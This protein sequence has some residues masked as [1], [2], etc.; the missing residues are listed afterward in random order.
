MVVGCFWQEGLS[1]PPTAPKSAVHLGVQSIGATNEAGSMGLAFEEFQQ[2]MRIRFHCDNAVPSRAVDSRF[3]VFLRVQDE[4]MQ[5][6]KADESPGY[7]EAW[8][9]GKLGVQVQTC[10]QW[11]TS[12][13]IG[14][15]FYVWG[16]CGSLALSLPSSL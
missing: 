14:T 7:L 8:Q 10:T 2:S 13:R 1:P 3:P 12:C 11:R 6:L 15:I 9:R 4:E 16:R 5:N